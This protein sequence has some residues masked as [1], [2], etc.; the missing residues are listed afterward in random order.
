M[1]RHRYAPLYMTFWTLFIDSVGIVH[2]ERSC[3]SES[4]LDDGHLGLPCLGPRTDR[5]THLGTILEREDG[6][7]VQSP[8][9][10]RVDRAVIDLDLLLLLANGISEA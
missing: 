9:K 3:L 7:H 6:A 5:H 8:W 4:G 10:Y 2:V 1:N